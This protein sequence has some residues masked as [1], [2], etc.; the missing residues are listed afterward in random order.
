MITLNFFQNDEFINSQTFNGHNSFITRFIVDGPILYTI[1]NDHTARS[2]N[3]KTGRQLTTYDSKF[4]VNSKS[5]FRG[6]FRG[7]SEPSELQIFKF[8]NFF[9]FRIKFLQY[10][11][12]YWLINL[13]HKDSVTCIDVFEVDKGDKFIVTGS[14]D[15]KVKVYPA[16]DIDKFKSKR[17]S[18]ASFKG[19]KYFFQSTPKYPL[20]KF[21]FRTCKTCV[22]SE[23]I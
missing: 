20:L 4:F 11:N 9:V 8:T 2:W 17:R 7:N 14:A 6:L 19:K 1:S 23:R 18:I 16:T 12:N 13:G 21:F 5:G 15:K 3:I 10:Q 22:W